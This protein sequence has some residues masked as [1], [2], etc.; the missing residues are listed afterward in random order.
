MNLQ[1]FD[2]S[3]RNQHGLLLAGVDEAGCGPWAGPVV[4]A[5][6]ILNP[7]YLHPYLLEHLND[8]KKILPKKRQ[9]LADLLYH[10]EKGAITSIALATVEEI[11][12]F[13]IRN[14]AILAMERALAGLNPSPS[15][16]IVDGNAFPAIKGQGH[17]IIKGDSQS[18]SIA[19]ASVVAKVHR[20]HLLDTYHQEYPHY[21]WNTNKGYG[22]KEHQKGL[23]ERGITL[24]HRR[25]F[26]PVAAY[27]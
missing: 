17:T 7:S 20:D 5:A 12:Q 11:D 23:K 26:K 16:Y 13:N 8:S 19:A 6:V 27:L 14:A 22:T 21:G 4:A 1:L 15:Y 9:Y 3:L 2:Q 10:S 18:L 25:S 24:H